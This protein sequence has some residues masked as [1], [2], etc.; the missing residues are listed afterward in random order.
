MPIL[1]LSSVSIISAF[2]ALSSNLISSLL[3]VINF[4]AFSEESAEINSISTSVPA[5][6]LI[7][8]T[9]SSILHPITSTY[10]VF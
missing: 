9:T 7:R 3:S 10:S 5:S 2:A 6:P 1:F 8:S 4:L